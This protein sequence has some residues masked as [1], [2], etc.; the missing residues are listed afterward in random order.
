[1]SDHIN[2]SRVD[3][4]V[5]SI[6]YTGVAYRFS[7]VYRTNKSVA[8]TCVLNV[9][10]V[11]LL[12]HDVHCGRNGRLWRSDDELYLSTQADYTIAFVCTMLILIRPARP[13]VYH[14]RSR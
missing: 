1:M 3:A 8:P 12:L 4:V 14:C 7:G 6:T 2:I 5:S 10:G 11:V 9:S 13:G